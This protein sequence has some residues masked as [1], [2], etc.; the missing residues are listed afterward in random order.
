MELLT[1]VVKELVLENVTRRESTYLQQ[2][3]FLINRNKEETLIDKKINTTKRTRKVKGTKL[4]KG[5]SLKMTIS[6][7]AHCPIT[8][9][10]NNVLHKQDNPTS[11]RKIPYLVR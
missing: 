1:R 2:I 7:Y 11:R 5:N 10:F 6:F 3:C 9:T 4:I 8:V